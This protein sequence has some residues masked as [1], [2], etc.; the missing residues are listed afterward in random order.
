MK[1]L[2]AIHEVICDDENG[3]SVARAPGTG[4]SASDEVA[5]MLVD[6]GAAR[7][8]ELT[9]AELTGDLDLKKLN[10]AQLLALAE[11]RQ[12]AVDPDATTAVIVAALEAAEDSLV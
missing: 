4:F 5:T 12:V 9:V 3:K 6:L 1:Q 11:D 10:K 2:I 8:D 7:H